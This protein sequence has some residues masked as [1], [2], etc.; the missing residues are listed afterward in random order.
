MVESIFKNRT[1]RSGVLYSTTKSLHFPIF[2]SFE[3]Y[4]IPRSLTCYCTLFLTCYSV[5]SK[6][7]PKCNGV[8]D[9]LVVVDFCNPIKYVVSFW[10]G[11]KVC[12][13]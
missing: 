4:S 2:F 7:F 8:K 11:N 5:L 3:S 9:F 1:S 6:L 12:T 10:Y 13:F